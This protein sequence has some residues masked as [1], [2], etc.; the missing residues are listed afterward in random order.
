MSGSSTP[1]EL[2]PDAFTA[3]VGAAA[4]A[5]VE[6]LASNE[7]KPVWRPAEP[8]EANHEP[9][10]PEQGVS[11]AS[12]LTELFDE[13]LPRGLQ[14]RSAGYMAYMPSGGLLS[15]A[16]ADLIASSV[17]RYVG[18]WAASPGLVELET[19]VI[20]WFADM[21]GYPASSR[22]YLASGGSMANFSAVLCAR[23]FGA[24]RSMSRARA[25]GSSV[26]HHSMQKALMMAG[27]SEESFVKVKSDAR[28]EIS[29]S[30]LRTQISKDRAAG[31]EPFMI[32]ATAGS[33]MTGSVDPLAAL[34][35]LAEDESLWLHVD[36]AYGGFFALTESGRTT[37]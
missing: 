23:R 1:L 30:A 8:S 27:F 31:F 20:R 21:V 17:N 9:T 12:V 6:H 33:T 11:M 19:R 13:V 29:M 26:V 37:L 34:A 15:S 32:L 3:M 35:E 16:V 14:T 10:V 36:A 22:G 18:N 2:S 24:F 7:H 4:E 28:G 25:Y 5:V